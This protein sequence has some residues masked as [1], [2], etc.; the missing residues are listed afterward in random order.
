[1]A[2]APPPPPPWLTRG[3]KMLRATKRPATLRRHISMS[4]LS[5][6]QRN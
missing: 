1:M 5:T 3:E 2:L 6:F 4:S